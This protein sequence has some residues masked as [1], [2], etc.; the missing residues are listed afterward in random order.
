MPSTHILNIVGTVAIVQLVCDLLANSY[1]FRGDVYQRAVN[2]WRREVQKLAKCGDTEKHKARRNRA[3]ADVAEAL[4]EISKQHMI[5]NFYTS[6]IFLLLYRIF[7]TEYHGNVVAVLPFAPYAWIRTATMRGLEVNAE[8]FEPQ[9]GIQDIN[10]LCSFI[11]IYALTTMSVKYYVNK[12]I[13]TNPPKGAN[14]GMLAMLDAP[15][16][17]RMLKYWGLDSEALEKLK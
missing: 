16:S 1:V 6:L 11:F 14:V 17:Q 7:A 12:L 9:G 13:G 4:A 10:Q 5:P 2:R 15:S 8:K 3:I